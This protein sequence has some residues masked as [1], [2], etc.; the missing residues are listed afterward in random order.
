MGSF[1]SASFSPGSFRTA[2]RSTLASIGVRSDGDMAFLARDYHNGRC[3]RAPSQDRVS[4]QTATLAEVLSQFHSE[5]LG[6]AKQLLQEFGS[7]AA[8]SNANEYQLRRFEA[9]DETWVD[10]FVAARKLILCGMF[11]RAIRTNIYETFEPLCHYLLATLG[12]L[13]HERLLAFFVDTAGSVLGEEI[14]AEGESGAVKLPMRRV[15]G[16]AISLDSSAVVLAHNHPSG[17]SE[18]SAADVSS[19]KALDRTMRGLGLR[20]WDHLI[21]GSGSVTSLRDRGH[22]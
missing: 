15:I 3:D 1:R 9:E 8:I 21:V 4:D 18:P 22:I 19:T 17:S 14:I 16:R 5:P 2:A 11:E 13:H 20:V 7:I 10:R 12:A 6:V